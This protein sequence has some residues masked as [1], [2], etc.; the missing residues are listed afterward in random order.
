M[1]LLQGVDK[2]YNPGQPDACAAL[3]QVDLKVAR[4][5]LVALSGVSGSGKSTLLSVVGALI[6][7]TR[8]QVEVA[9]QNV[10]KLPDHHASRFR[11]QT[12]GFIFQNHNLF[13]DL[14]VRDNLRAPLVPRGLSR[15]EEEV[16][17]ARALDLAAIGHKADQKV[18]DLS[19]GERQRCAIARALV[20][21]PAL[22]LCDEPTAHL[23]QDNVSLFAEVLAG[24]KAA[25]KT[26]VVATHDPR[27]ESLDF[28]DRVVPLES[29]K[30][31]DR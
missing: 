5:E 27:L 20:T 15:G 13:A 11:N 6:R 30:I 16:H 26:L 9:G 24:M 12:V 19:G 18:R 28:I 10:A 29:G 3:S 31:V 2:I 17:L 8:G 7:P 25:G 23:D 4:G 21:D 22:V 1:I 14:T